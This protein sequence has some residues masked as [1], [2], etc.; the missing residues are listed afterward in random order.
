MSGFSLWKIREKRDILSK[1]RA[2][3]ALRKEQLA[4]PAAAREKR[5]PNET[6][7]FEVQ[8][9]VLWEEKI[10]SAV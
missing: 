9:R 5:E 4:Q 6:R 7:R 10:R 2:N 1:R 8:R 3:G